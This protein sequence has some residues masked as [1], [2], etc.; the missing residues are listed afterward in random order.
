MLPSLPQGVMQFNFERWP[1]KKWGHGED[2]YGGPYNYAVVECH[3]AVFSFQRG[4]Y[5]IMSALITID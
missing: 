3:L 2:T 4:H 1:V 5:A